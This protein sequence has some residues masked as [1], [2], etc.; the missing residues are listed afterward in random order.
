MSTPNVPFTTRTANNLVLSHVR[1]RAWVE[2][3]KAAIASN[4]YNLCKLVGPKSQLMAVVKADG[5]GHG[6]LNAAEAAQS[7]GA[8]SYGV[9]TLHEGIQLREGGIQAPILVLGNITQSE[10]LRACKEWDLMPTI[11]TVREIL[12]CE[13]LAR[14]NGY[15]ISIHIKIDTGMTRLGINWEEGV[16]M[17]KVLKE[18]NFVKIVGI[19]SHLALTDQSIVAKQ[20][21]QVQKQRW[22]NVLHSLSQ[23]QIGFGYRHLANSAGTLLNNELG[24]DM[25]RVG[26]AIYGQIPQSNLGRIHSLQPALHL[27][28]RVTLIRHVPAGVGIS[29]GHEYITSQPSRIAVVSIGYGDGVPRVLSGKM[30]VLFQGECVR[31]VGNITMDQLM[32]DATN[33]KGLRV[34]SVVTLLG[35]SGGRQ[36]NAFDW[37]QKCNTIPWE[38]LCGLKDRLPRLVLNPND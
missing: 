11:S 16:R 38:I 15:I 20:F 12:L 3:D 8:S 2:I 24:F 30:E 5:Y 9:A 32:L 4:T 28:A 27:R 18:L 33:V 34:G 14:W 19:Y 35:S 31:Q 26:L 29:Y 10:E 22:V 37:S 7:G 6:A 13:S 25:I 21:T 23:H 17:I 1:Q 36:I